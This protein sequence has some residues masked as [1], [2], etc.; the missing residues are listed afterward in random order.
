MTARMKIALIAGYY[1]P[2]IKGGGEISTQILAEILTGA[3][4]DVHVLTCGTASSSTYEDGIAVERIRSPN[5]YW[6]FDA[7]P[8]PL[9]KIGWHLAENVNPRAEKNV[10]DFLEKTAADILVTSTIENF[11]AAA[12]KAAHRANVPSAHILRSYYPF[13]F[14][15]NAVRHGSNCTGQ[16]ASCNLLSF[17]RRPASN[18]VDGVVGIS[19]YI[20]QRHRQHGFFTASSAAVI[21]EPIA[22]RFFRDRDDLGRPTRFGYLGVLSADKGLE[23]LADAWRRSAPPGC[24]LS[25]AGRGKPAYVDALRTRFPADVEFRGW[26]DGSTYLS[27]IDYL[28]VPSIWNEPFGRIVIEAFAAGVPVLGSRIGGIAETVVDGRNGYTFTPNDT[29]DLANFL[30][31]AAALPVSDYAELARGARRAVEPYESSAIAQRHLTFYEQL[32]GAHAAALR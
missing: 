16:C 22:R 25:I 7:R 18:T 30:T 29:E 1:P 6:D 14:R 19:E 2:D 15:G 9:A 8:S 26:V 3:G 17:G 10:A 32:I 20:L 21:P 11:G 27:T 13:C 23:S 5:L 12:W 31:F 4:A 24:S 28:V